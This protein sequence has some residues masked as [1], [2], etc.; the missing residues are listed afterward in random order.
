MADDH[1][2]VG[3]RDVAMMPDAVGSEPARVSGVPGRLGRVQALAANRGC[4]CVDGWVVDGVAVTGWGGGG[5]W[6]CG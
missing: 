1:L 6:R 2:S 5:L 3:E 4:G